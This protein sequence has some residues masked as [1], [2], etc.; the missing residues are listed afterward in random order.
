ML[1]FCKQL[2]N[3][4]ENAG[5]RAQVSRSIAWIGIL[6]NDTSRLIKTEISEFTAQRLAISNAASP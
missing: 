4:K 3:T 6:A 1:I 2:Q 5:Q